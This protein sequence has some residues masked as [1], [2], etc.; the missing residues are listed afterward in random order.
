MGSLSD[1]QVLGALF[2]ALVPG[3]LAFRLAT[4]LYK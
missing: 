2:V 1:V 3:I 4:E